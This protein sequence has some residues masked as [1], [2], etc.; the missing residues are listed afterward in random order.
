MNG[1][2]DSKVNPNQL[3][4]EEWVDDVFR[5]S[6]ASIQSDSEAIA[7]SRDQLFQIIKTRLNSIISECPNDLQRKAYVSTGL[8]LSSAKNVY[9]DKDLFIQRT[10][11]LIDLECSPQAVIDFLAWLEEWARSNAAAVVEELPPSAVLDL[12]RT[13]WI[14]ATPMREIINAS[15][16]ADEICKDIYGYRIPWLINAVAQLL[17]ISDLEE[18]ADTLGNIGMLVELGVPTTSAAMVFLAGVRSRVAATELSQTSVDL[19]SS[20]NQV[21]RR[22]RDEDVVNTLRQEVS[23]STIAW[24]DLHWEMYEHVKTTLPDF[25]RFK[26]SHLSE[27][28]DDIIVRSHDGNIYLCSPD[29]KERFSVQS[30]DS[31]PF[32]KVPDDYRVSFHRDGDIYELFVRDPRIEADKMIQG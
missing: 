16:Q 26:C 14:N 28:V 29:G 20:I 12:I 2:E 8:P 9:C 15:G 11:I 1:Y 21:K 23:E 31:L 5:A 3:N 18:G 17:R 10:Q 13:S 24:L 6:L 27:Q 32:S 4:P 22:L 19:G 25:A 30:T 7:I